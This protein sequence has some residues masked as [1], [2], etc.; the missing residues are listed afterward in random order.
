LTGCDLQG[1]TAQFLTL[2]SLNVDPFWLNFIE[3]SLLPPLGAG[4]QDPVP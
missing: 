3:Q 2:S 4:C 1:L